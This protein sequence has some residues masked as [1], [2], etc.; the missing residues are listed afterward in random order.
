MF[1]NEMLNFYIILTLISLILGIIGALIAKRKKRSAIGWF[2]FCC[3]FLFPIFIII[4]L[5]PN[6][7]ESKTKENEHDAAS[8]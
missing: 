5:P 4:K 7:E 1:D 2:I 3:V 8:L 6:G